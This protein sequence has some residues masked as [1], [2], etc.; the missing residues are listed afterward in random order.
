MVNGRCDSCCMKCEMRSVNCH[1]TC[2]KY[3]EYR[4][5]INNISLARQKEVV[6]DTLAIQRFVKSRDVLLD[7]KKHG[8]KWTLV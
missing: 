2:E 8:R 5:L 6:K 3:A 7:K 4:K 1:A